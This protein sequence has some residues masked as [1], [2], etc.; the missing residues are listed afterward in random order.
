V[1]DG[2]S[3]DPG[4]GSR[5]DTGP[6]RDPALVLGAKG[7]A[8]DR[9]AF[10]ADLA[11]AYYE[12]HLTQAQIAQLHGISRSQ[13]S[14]YLTEARDEGIVQVRIIAPGERDGELESRL[15]QAFP[16]LREVAVA[17]VFDQRP[18]LVRRAVARVMAQLVDRLV[19]PGQ[20]VCMGAGR[21]LALVA[22]MLP[23]R[24]FRGVIV[25]PATGNAGHAA[26]ESDYTAVCHAVAGAWG[27][28]AYAI[29]APA[30]L[31]RGAS[32]AQLERSNP[33]I[34]QALAAARHADLFVLGLG[35]LAGDEIFVRTGLI[36]AAELADV[37]DAGAVGD[38][39]GNFFD[40]AGA[41]VDGPFADRV[42]GIG[43]DDVRRAASAF[44]CAGG[45][46]KV[47]AIIA[48]LRGGTA[49]SLVTDEHTARGVLD[50]AGGRPAA[51]VKEPEREGRLALTPARS[52]RTGPEGGG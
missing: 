34:R 5:T 6:L 50:V 36:S 3:D 16:G 12:Q 42:V 23:R 35:S 19:R 46:E 51:V 24:P 52:E 27:A 33:Q 2:A 26:H 11:R 49:H 31:G 43:L 47:P 14:R 32:A 17:R 7:A 39:C 48:V 1:H 41:A 38:L 9:G 28:L 18:M 4:D 20:T 37:R 44:V 10:L 40:A 30:I 25:V 8:P 29:N 21:T 45:A 13:I 22:E 15:R